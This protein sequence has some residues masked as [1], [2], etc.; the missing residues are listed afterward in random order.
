[1]DRLLFLGQHASIETADLVVGWDY[2]AS[3]RNLVLIA[4]KRREEKAVGWE[5]QS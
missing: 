4:E 2:D 3:P 1:M 5:D